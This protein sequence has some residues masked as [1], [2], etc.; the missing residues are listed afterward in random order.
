MS[1][2]WPPPS[3][4]AKQKNTQEKK[5][6]VAGEQAINTQ[7]NL[8]GLGTDIDD[9][10]IDDICDEGNCETHYATWTA[11]V[12]PAPAGRVATRQRAAAPR[13]RASRRSPRRRAARS[14]ARRSSPHGELSVRPPYTKN[15]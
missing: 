15:Y 10:G 14:A 6:F 2:G 11:P 8:N 5:T 9:D 4:G 12:S 7:L 1:C 13:R 3:S